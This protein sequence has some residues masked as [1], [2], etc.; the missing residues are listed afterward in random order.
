MSDIFR[1][2]VI[3]RA[4]HASLD[5]ATAA[6]PPGKHHAVLFDGTYSDATG[7]SMRAVFVRR[8]DSGW[9]AELA[10]AYSGPGGVASKVTIAKSW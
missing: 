2:D 8:T 4:V 5:E 3:A 1:Q 6:I 10:G 9:K 7:A